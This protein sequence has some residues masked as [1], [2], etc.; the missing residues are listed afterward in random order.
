MRSFYE[1]WLSVNLFFTNHKLIFFLS[2]LFSQFQPSR[3]KNK[4]KKD[5]DPDFHFVGSKSEYNQDVWNDITKYIKRK[6]KSKV[7]D[8]ILEAR[9]KFKKEVSS[10]L[11]LNFE[12]FFTFRLNN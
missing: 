12:L 7:D 9:K 1:L 6:A 4:K 10:V 2:F 11:V 3:Q 8:K 5:F